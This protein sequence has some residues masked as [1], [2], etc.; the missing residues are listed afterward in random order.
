MY[1]AP[2]SVMWFEG[3]HM[4]QVVAQIVEVGTI[5]QKLAVM[6]NEH[7]DSGVLISLVIL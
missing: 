7:R 2:T 1:P 3:S 5:F 6:V 4:S